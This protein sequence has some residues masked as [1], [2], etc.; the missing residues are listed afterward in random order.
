MCQSRPE[1]DEQEEDEEDEDKERGWHGQ[2]QP[3]TAGTDTGHDAN[4]NTDISQ[5]PGDGPQRPIRK[6]T[7]QG[8]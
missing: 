2:L 7:L 1:E 8:Q 5:Q 6:C 3:T 4:A